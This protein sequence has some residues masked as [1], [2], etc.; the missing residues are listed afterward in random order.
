MKETI[1]NIIKELGISAN[2][3]G[4][5]YI[6]FAVEAII[7]DASLINSVTKVLYPMIA[8]E[9]NDTPL[10]VERTMRHAIEVA[11]NR[12][13]TDLL[14]KVFGYGYDYSKGRPTNSEFIFTL[15]DYVMIKSA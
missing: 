13:D 2:L 12:A 14:V 11:F 15:A 9:F 6:R 5:H 7:K 4:Y 3:K 10:R 8:K 1:T